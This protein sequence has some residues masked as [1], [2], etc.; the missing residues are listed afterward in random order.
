ME[1]NERV[2]TPSGISQPTSP[3]WVRWSAS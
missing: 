1:Q 3:C 2:Q